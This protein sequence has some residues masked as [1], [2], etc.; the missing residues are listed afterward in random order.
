MKLTLPGRYMLSDHRE[1]SCWTINI[2][3]AG[4]TVL[5]QQK[6]HIGERVVLNI[7]QIG[8]LEGTIAR[9]FD[10]W[11]AVSLQLSPSK[12]EQLKEILTWLVNH[13]TQ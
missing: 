1:H 10:A 4:I 7:E 13:R 12:C 2:S 6:G 11:F 8:R 9:N 3:L 5:E